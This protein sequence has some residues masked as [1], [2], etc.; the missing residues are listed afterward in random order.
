LRTSLGGL[1][2]RRP[3]TLLGIVLALL[4]IAAFVLVAINASNGS[5]GQT[6]NVVVATSNLSPRIPIDGGS[7]EIKPIPVP[8]GYPS[9][10]FTK[11]DDVKGMI[12][13]VSIVGG[14]AITANMVAKPN[15]QLGSTS[16]FPPA[17]SRESRATS[18][19]TITSPSSPPSPPEPRWRARRSSPTFT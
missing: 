1:T 19:P 16:E 8:Q 18:S 17:S 11:I 15:Q 9:V 12:P 4:V 5:V 7:L 2:S 3:F 10:F 6:L 13:L 14:Q